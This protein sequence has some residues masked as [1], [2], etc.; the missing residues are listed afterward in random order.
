MALREPLNALLNEVD[1]LDAKDVGGQA[2]TGRRKE[3]V[4]EIRAEM[5]AALS[6][7]QVEKKQIS[8]WKDWDERIEETVEFVRSGGRGRIDGFRIQ[9][10]TAQEVNHLEKVR[11]ASQT[12][13]PLRRSGRDG[14]PDEHDPHYEKALQ[15]WE[16]ENTLSNRLHMLR[17]IEIGFAQ[18][19]GFEIPGETEEE[20]LAALEAKVSG[21]VV[22]LFVAINR[23]SN[24]TE[25][26][27]APF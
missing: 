5:Q 7:D 4:K 20:K 3:L 13:R 17:V 19:N 11:Q 24:L 14:R 25:E 8:S 12:P 18:A 2:A 15:K 22:R 23:I 6:P 27:L 9:S 1:K 21:D 26:T 16:Q 10:L